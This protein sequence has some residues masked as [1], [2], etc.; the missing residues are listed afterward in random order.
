MG[1]RFGGQMGARSKNKIKYAT[2]TWSKTTCPLNEIYRKQ[3]VLFS[4][5][6]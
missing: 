2:I 5:R 1:D 6:V 3:L 4:S